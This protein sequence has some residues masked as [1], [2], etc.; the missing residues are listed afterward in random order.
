MTKPLLFT[1]LSVVLSLSGHGQKTEPFPFTKGVYGDAS[2]FHKNGMTFKSLGINA[3]FV[4]SAS[5]TPELYN[6]AREDGVRVYAEFP[7][8][9]GKGYVED[10]PEAWPVNEK[11]ERAPIAD[12]FMG[13]CLTD[14]G[15]RKHR[16]DELRSLLSKYQVDGV[17]LDY[18]HWH[19][20]FETP[21]PILPETCFCERCIG[22]FQEKM[23]VEVPQGE[24]GERSKWILL[25]ADSTWRLW[26][27]Q[28]LNDW[29]R[30]MRDIVKAADPSALLGIYYCPWYP[31]D[32][33]GAH[34]RILG[35][36]MK[37]L[38]E[39][40][41]VFSPMLYHHMMERPANWVSD[42]VKWL[43]QAGITD[44]KDPM[45]WPIV[46]AHNK[47]GII[48]TEEFREVMWNGSRAPSSGIMM[49]TLHTLIS[50]PGKLEVMKDL[51]RKR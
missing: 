18:L 34:Y 13:V 8:L 31:D 2:A 38:A 17:W 36:N 43:E 9:N 20:Q 26:R 7:T 15:F 47:P 32:Y 1:V 51:Y 46:Q 42:Y 25:K 35:L 24:T 33:R 49:F 29:V 6:T 12:W 23:N 44:G 30:G 37:A 28:V 3:I 22:K 41:D 50:E 14:P 39:I 10:H 11:G 19:A 45:I 16:E 48:T 40:A 4:G 21:N 5:I 27:S